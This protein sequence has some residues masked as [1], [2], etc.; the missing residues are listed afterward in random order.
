MPFWG[1]CEVAKCCIAKGHDHCGQCQEFP[2]AILNAYA[3]QPERGDN[4]KRLLNL[5]AWNE[6][7][8]AMSRYKHA[9][10]SHGDHTAITEYLDH[11]LPMLMQEAH[12]PGVSV[13]AVHDGRIVWAKGYGLVNAATQT[14]IV[15]DTIFEAASLSKPLFAY[16][17]LQLCQ[18]GC[19]DLDRPLI[20]YAPERAV[21]DDLRSEHITARMVLSHNSGLVHWLWNPG[22]KIRLL[23][24]PGERFSYSSLGLRYLQEVVEHVTGEPLEPLMQRTLHS[25]RMERSSYIWQ[26]E[27]ERIAAVGHDDQGRP[28]EKQ[29]P[30]QA[31]SYVSLHTTP[32]EYACLLIEMMSAREDGPRPSAW[33]MLIPQVSCGEGVWWGLGWGLEQQNAG[34]A[35]WHW[36]DTGVFKAFVMGAPERKKGVVVM[37]NGM[38]GLS[39]CEHVVQA[40]MPGEHPAFAWITDFYR[41]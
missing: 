27:Y 19:L 38:G 16:A 35:F 40:W 37:A 20:E 24:K 39:V 2:C 8:Y 22:E 10:P 15:T 34:K 12:L 25:L 3:Y 9:M 6:M 30:A 14:P 17:V 36:G 11:V 41:E 21:P 26:E 13:A 29:K 4:G 5:K 18:R 7:G 31:Q 33:D 23:F 32:V 1:E 28:T